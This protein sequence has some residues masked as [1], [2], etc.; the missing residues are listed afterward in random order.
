MKDSQALRVPSVE[1]LSTRSSSQLRCGG[2]SR[3]HSLVSVFR[4]LSSRLY[5][6]MMTEIS[7]I[8]MSTKQTSYRDWRASHDLRA[9]DGA[10][11]HLHFGAQHRQRRRF[12]HTPA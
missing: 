5:E 1:L 10:C 9:E 3:S 12:Q 11:S 4:R 2:I 7:I 8:V 6:Q